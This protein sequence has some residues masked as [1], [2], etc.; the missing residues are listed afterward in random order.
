LAA[1]DEDHSAVG[2]PSWGGTVARQNIKASLVIYG[3]IPGVGWRRGSVV[4]AKNGRA[5]PGVMRCNG[6]EYPCPNGVYQIRTY[7]G[8]KAVYTSV[9]NDFDKAQATLERLI[10]TRQ[11]EQA[12]MSLGIKLPEAKEKPKTLMEL[13]KGFIEKYAHGSADSEYAYRYVSGEFVRLMGQRKKKY[14][15]DL[16]EDDVIAFDRHLEEMGNQKNTRATRYGYVRCFLRFCG[17]DPAKVISE[18]EHKKLKSKPKL[19]VQTYTEAELTQLYAASS[20]RHRLIWRAF[21]ELGLRDEELAFAFWSDV[22]LDNGVWH[23]RFKPAGSFSWNSALAWKSKDSEERDLPISSGLLMELRGLRKYADRKC[24]LVFPTANG[25][26]DI[27]LLKAL[28]SDWRAAGLNCGHCPGCTGKKNECSRAKLKT[29]RATYL[30]T[31]LRFTHLRNVQA[32]AGHS[33]ISTTQRYLAVDNDDNLKQ[34]ANA[35]FGS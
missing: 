24:P 8:N 2:I 20:E 5:K 31:M 4:R 35:A 9:G 28:K 3:N 30:S 6:M 11:L 32:L 10:A 13:R 16:I 21:R 15:T 27:K 14:A 19:A 33:D 25:R 7:T 17:L 26:P 23:V 29:F 12:Q 34:A 18:T 22:D 1:T